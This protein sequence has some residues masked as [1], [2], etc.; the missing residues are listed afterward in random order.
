MKIIEFKHEEGVE[1][2]AGDN[3]LDIIVYYFTTYQD[4]RIVDEICQSFE[5]VSIREVTGDD[6]T[7]KRLFRSEE[8]GKDELAS[9]EDLAKAHVNGSEPTLL[10]SPSY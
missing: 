6:L 4:R 9:Y 10:V 1:V 8:S 2:L 3:T 5:G 7:F